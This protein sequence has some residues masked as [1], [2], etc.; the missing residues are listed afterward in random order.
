MNALRVGRTV[1]WQRP[2]GAGNWLL[3][4]IGRITAWDVTSRTINLSDG[5]IL[6]DTEAT[7]LTPCG[8]ELGRRRHRR[9]SEYPCNTCRGRQQTRRK[10]AA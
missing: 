6:L 3:E 5:T 4:G 7:A 2:A 9:R 1:Y 10:E 8:T